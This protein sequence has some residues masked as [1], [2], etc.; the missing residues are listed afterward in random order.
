MTESVSLTA[1][2]T[3][4]RTRPRML[5]ATSAI[6]L[7]AYRNGGFMTILPVLRELGNDYQID[8]VFPTDIPADQLSRPAMEELQT[9][10][11]RVVP[12]EYRTTKL[13]KLLIA[14]LHSDSI[15]FY[16][17]PR[18]FLI[19]H[20]EKLIS[21]GKYDL[22]VAQDPK[23]GRFLSK[24][25]A[26]RGIASVLVIGDYLELMF[27]RIAAN[28]T[29]L[30][31]RAYHALTSRR[32]KKAEPSLYEAFDAVVYVS[33][34]DRK[35]LTHHHPS[36]AG[37]VRV[38]PLAV[39]TDEQTPPYNRHVPGRMTLLF[40]GNMTFEPNKQAA[41]WL[42]GEILP[43]LR[44][45]D[46]SF[47]LL[48]VGRSAD[49]LRL[50]ESDDVEIHSSVPSISPFYSQADVFL[51]PVLSGTGVKLKVLEAMSAGL[52]V[53]GTTLSY[54]G[55]DVQDEEHCL[56]ADTP[57]S[58]ADALARLS[59]DV[60]FKSKVA[61]RGQ[62]YVRLKHSFQSVAGQWEALFNCLISDRSDHA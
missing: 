60:E 11:N 28:S 8:I 32:L 21:D 49:E 61:D 26:T 41:E 25:A 57:S 37:K 23:F 50:A 55:L 62:T 13:R 46:I 1:L 47:R 36:L 56:I 30:V 27:R 58:F 17:F 33:N 31:S 3:R 38:I 48:I 9:Y 35:E 59:N 22:V 12:L 29:S 10:C 44:R 5:L 39:E 40:T 34:E 43:E 7:P 20:L 53:V 14:L 2:E 54:F 6:P 4:A 19:T 52:P 16:L 18:S 24:E 51:S 15:V 42:L 45:R